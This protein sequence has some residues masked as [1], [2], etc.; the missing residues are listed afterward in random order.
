MK[1]RDLLL[2]GAAVGAAAGGL[3]W[4]LVNRLTEPGPVEIIRGGEPFPE[5]SGTTLAGE[6]VVLP[7]DIAGRVGLLVM[8]FDYAVR[9]EVEQWARHVAMRYGE[10][11]SL[12]WYVLPMIG[13]IGRLM[14]TAIDSAMVRG[15]PADEQSHILTIY[16]DLRWLRKR[17]GVLDTSQAYVYLIGRTGRL[18]WHTEGSLTTEKSADLDAALEK[19]DIVPAQPDWPGA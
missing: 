4:L 18:V 19:Q 16:G 11:P 1:P 5:L 15:T 10:M 3:T 12:A 17:L 7:A 13:G 2:A 6:P 9:F 14:R 8:G